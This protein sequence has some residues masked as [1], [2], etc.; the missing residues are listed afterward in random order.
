VPG[1]EDFFVDLDRV[2]RF[3]DRRIPLKIIGSAALMLQTDYQRGTKDSDV[4]D[5][6]DLTREIRDRLI[7]LAGPGTALWQRHRV[8]IEIVASGIPFLPVAS[9]WHPWVPVGEPLRCFELFALDVVDVVV[10]KIK[11]LNANDLDDI[12][13]MIEQGRVPH[14]RLVERF[15]GAVDV[16]AY[17]A[18]ADDL[19]GYVDNLHRIERD[20]LGV[21]ETDIELP[22]WV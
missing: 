11:R 4:L 22:R 15:R 3:P 1:V 9:S 16:F 21:D 18:R 8:Y 20:L 17:D 19:P 5:T 2:W 12:T 6:I 14:D 13:A 10:S 7:E